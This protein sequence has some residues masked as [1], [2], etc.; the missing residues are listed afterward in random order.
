[1][2]WR[3]GTA[4]TKLQTCPILRDFLN[5]RLQVQIALPTRRLST[6][7]NVAGSGC[8][9]NADRHA[10]QVLAERAGEDHDTRL[11]REPNRNASLQGRRLFRCFSGETFLGGC[12]AL[13]FHGGRGNITNGFVVE[14]NA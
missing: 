12:R 5:E 2:C 3:R 14:L 1:M 13:L 9:S 8:R 7:L 4:A 10:A 6:S 11:G